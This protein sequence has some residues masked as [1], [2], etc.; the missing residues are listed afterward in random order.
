[1]FVNVTIKNK[2]TGALID[3]DRDGVFAEICFNSNGD[4]EIEAI[5]TCVEN[6]TNMEQ[7]TVEMYFDVEEYEIVSVEFIN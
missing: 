3:T 1:M 2:N 6:S 7:D 5:G 4:I